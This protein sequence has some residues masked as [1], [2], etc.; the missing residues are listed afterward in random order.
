M[1]WILLSQDATFNNST[2]LWVLSATLAPTLGWVIHVTYILSTVKADLCKVKKILEDPDM[3]GMGTNRTNA[4]IS[5]NTH[6]V[7]ALTHYIRWFGERQ[8]GQIPPPPLDDI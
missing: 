1:D 4:V 6:A 8:I 5:D 7:Q 3:Y 2:A